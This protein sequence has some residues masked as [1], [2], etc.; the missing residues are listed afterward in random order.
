[1]S[2]KEEQINKQSKY[3]EKEGKS[4]ALFNSF[5]YV[6]CYM[7]IDRGGGALL[8]VGTA[9]SACKMESKVKVSQKSVKD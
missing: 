2:N 7:Y 1:M 4:Y 5:I 9:I 8:V 3:A 6:A